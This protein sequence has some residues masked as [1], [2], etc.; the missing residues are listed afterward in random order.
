MSEL[1]IDK[2]PSGLASDPQ[3]GTSGFRARQETL[4]WIAF[5]V[6]I[7]AA[8]RSRMC[9][10]AV[11]VMVTAS[12]NDVCDNGFKIVDH[13]GR[14][15]PMEWEAVC[16]RVVAAN[17]AP[18]AVAQL[19][20]LSHTSSPSGTTQTGS[21]L[22]RPYVYIMQ[23]TRLSCDR[24]VSGVA[25]GVAYVDNGMSDVLGMGATPVI[26]HIVAAANGYS[27]PPYQASVDGY[28][29]R[30]ANGLE[31]LLSGQTR[32]PT[33]PYE[34]VVDCAAGV[35]FVTLSKLR[36]YVTPFLKK[37]LG[38]NMLLVNSPF[39]DHCTLNHN[40]GAEHVQKNYVWP[41]LHPGVAGHCYLASLDGDADRLVFAAGS[42]SAT[43][44]C[45]VIDGD[46]I[47]IL[48]ATFIQSQV[49]ILH[50]D[51]D[52]SSVMKGLTFGL[53]QTAYANG[54]STRYAAE[55]LKAF[56]CV[57]VKTGV[58][59]V[60]RAARTFDISVFFEANG[61]GSALFSDAAC[62][63]INQLV[64]SKNQ[65]TRV[66]AARLL[67]LYTALSQSVGDAIADMLVCEVVR[68]QLDIS[69]ERWLSLYSS[70]VVVNRKLKVKNKLVY[71]CNEDETRIIKPAAVQSRMDEIVSKAAH[72]NCRAF[73]RPSG[74]EDILRLYVEATDLGTASEVAA[75][76]AH[77]VAEFDASH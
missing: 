60:E 9:G 64:R 43:G 75:S 67:G 46:R 8:Y 2:K 73:V 7:L 22:F 34:L 5:R 50:G 31:L 56:R 37:S 32:A 10:K 77:Y 70:L 49:D 68:F 21:A 58:K 59:Y 13:D 53:I 6:G 52:A 51:S 18:E 15:L 63:A 44:T 36:Q 26:H 61:H 25:R 27:L 4:D 47:A 35:G 74:T 55:H 33:N 62:M 48:F 72:M 3:Y 66:A 19:E 1:Q 71:A 65:S 23:D 11:G 16:A 45:N 76:I 41:S 28:C 12:H 20:A 69:V 14:M 54:N 17:S 42:I 24:L 39:D 40:C 57:L 38:L 29:S 30:L